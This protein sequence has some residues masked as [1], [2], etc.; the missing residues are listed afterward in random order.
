MKYVVVLPDGA[1]DE[2]VARLGGRTP[3]EAARTPNLDRIV[4]LG[5]IGRVVTVPQELSPG[6]D[7]ATLSLFGYDPRVCHPGRAPLE[8]AARGIPVA[9]SEMI[10]RCNLVAVENGVMADFTAG[11]IDQEAAETLIRGLNAALCSA[12]CRLYPGVSYRHL[13]VLGEAGG[14]EVRCTPPHDIPNQ[15]VAPHLPV[16]KG[17]QRIL[18]IMQQARQ[19]LASHPVNHRRRAA[20]KAAATDIWLWGQGRASHLEPFFTRFGVRGA[21][22]A[23]V[24]LIRGI[25]KSVGMDI[26]DVEGATGYL[27]TNYAGKGEAVCRGLDSYDLVI[28]HIEAPDEAGH[29]GDTVGKVT[30]LER[31]D[32]HIVGPAL[33]ALAKL[34]EWRILVA[35]D[36]PTPVEKRVHTRTPPP[37]CIAGTGINPGMQK[38]FSERSAATSDFFF[39]AGHALMP[40]FLRP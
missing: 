25:A 38:E 11:H 30:A 3:L 17:S 2:P 32:E 21:A 20:G 35:P 19:F 23:A 24:D 10:F 7:V 40:F 26:L 12:G 13:L 14:M 16:G 18:D 31:I 36:H 1:A 29:Q 5:R 39:E 37:F 27:D 9:A 8:A 28:V 33:A 15:P 22:I 34:P 4:Q 6:S